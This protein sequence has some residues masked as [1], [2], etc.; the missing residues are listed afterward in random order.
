MRPGEMG[1]IM[2]P[3]VLQAAAYPANRHVYLADRQRTGLPAM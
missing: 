3:A 1:A 2:A